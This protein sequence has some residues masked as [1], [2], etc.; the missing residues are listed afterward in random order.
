MSVAASVP[1][2]HPKASA[3]TS[4]FGMVIFLASET[5]LFAG[6]IGSYIVLRSA[7]GTHWPPEGAPEIG[8]KWPLTGLN[9][10]MIVNTLILVASSFLFMR[11]ESSVKKRG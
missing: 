8:V 4:R 9:K 3:A 10:V 2:V 5:M 11:A 7:T 6:L 1:E